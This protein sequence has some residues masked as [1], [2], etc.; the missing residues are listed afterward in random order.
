MA[1][2]KVRIVEKEWICD[3]VPRPQVKWHCISQVGMAIKHFEKNTDGVTPGYTRAIA[4]L[5]FS[6]VL[7]SD[8]YLVS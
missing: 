6:S 3:Y 1:R 2:M 4:D 5:E 7:N 8:I